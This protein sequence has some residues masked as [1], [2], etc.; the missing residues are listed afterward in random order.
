MIDAQQVQ[1]GSVEVVDHEL[2]LN[3]AIAKVVGGSNHRATLHAAAGQ[4]E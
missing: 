1:H 3:H 2:L 4:P